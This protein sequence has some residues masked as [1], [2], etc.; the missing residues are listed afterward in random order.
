MSGVWCK[1]RESAVVASAIVATTTVLLAQESAPTI[2][3]V[4][5]TKTLS[6]IESLGS[7][8]PSNVEPSNVASEST[9]PFSR[10]VNMNSVDPANLPARATAPSNRFESV[11]LPTS[12]STV[13]AKKIYQP[14]ETGRAKV[15]PPTTTVPVASNQVA[16]PTAVA[17]PV[18]VS[19]AVVVD[20]NAPWWDAEVGLQSRAASQAV[21]VTLDSLLYSALRNSAQIRVFSDLPLIRETAISEADAAFDWTGF[22]DTRWDDINEPVGS[23]L[24]TGGPPRFEDQQLSGAIGL[25]RRNPLG[26]QIEVSQ[27]FGWQQNNSVFFVPNDQGTSRLTVSYTQPLMRGRGRVYNTS[28]TVLAQIDTKIARDEFSRQLQSHLLEVTRAYWSLYL[29]RAAL[30]QKRRLLASAEVILGDLER[31]QS[32]D[33]VASQVVRARA[34]VESR[35]A[36]ILRAEMAVKNAESRIRALTNDPAWGCS[37]DIELVPALMP[38]RHYTGADMQTA[39]SQ[40]MQSRPEVNQAIKQVKAACVR[41]S[42]AKNE[43]LPVLNMVLESYVAGLNGNSQVGGAFTDQFSEGEPSYSV[44]LQYEYPIWNRAARARLQRRRLE[45]RQLQNQFQ[46]TAETL[47]LEVAVAVREL[48]TSFREMEAKQRAMHASVAEVT[49]IGGTLES[50]RR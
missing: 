41:M 14:Y 11:D 20:P 24:T 32:L 26:G 12:Q 28:L 48:E 43:I 7:F 35:R 6:R 8:E 31:R 46:T 15:A 36:E 49:Y 34:A 22:M 2:L 19:P 40:A 21:P 37:D 1:L 50:P 45:V 5:A 25:R 27:R 38:L 30:L 18:P 13:G 17:Q 47:K 10:S 3:P 9:E 42:M 29:E 16:H 44:G 23:T 39:M 4:K 33:T